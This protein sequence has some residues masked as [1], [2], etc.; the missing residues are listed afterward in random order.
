MAIKI[1]LP[2]LDIL[3]LFFQ[4]KWIM[5]RSQVPSQAQDG[6]WF[7]KHR[8]CGDLKAR[9]QLSALKGVEGRGEDSGW[10]QEEGQTLVTH[11]N[12]HQANQ[13]VGQFAFQ[14]TLGA[15]TSHGQFQTH[16]THHSSNLGESTTFPHIVFSTLLCGTHIRMA[17]NPGT[18]KEEF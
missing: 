2:H 11:F 7:L 9:S 13:Q 5:T 17:F 16:K 12:L 8:N 18:P 4:I 15:R 14:S 6:P 10:D 3:N 1:Q